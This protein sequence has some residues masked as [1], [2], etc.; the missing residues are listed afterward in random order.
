MLK[1]KDHLFQIFWQ[2]HI[3]VK[4]KTRRLLK[5]LHKDNG[6]EYTF[7]QF[8][9]HSS[10]HSIQLKKTVPGAPRY[11]GVAKKMNRAILQGIKCA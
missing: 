1:S 3:M 7:N 9:S 5:C 10:K 11:N 8:R 2:F 4:R 6:G